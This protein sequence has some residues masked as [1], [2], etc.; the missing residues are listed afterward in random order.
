MRPF[1]RS[2]P[3]IK[4][5]TEESDASAQDIAENGTITFIDLDDVASIALSTASVTLSSGVTLPDG[6]QNTLTNGFSVTNNND[7]TASWSISLSDLD[8][9]FLDAD[10]TITVNFVV[11]ATDDQSAT[12]SDT[13]SLV[14]TGSN[15]TPTITS[16][17]SRNLI[18]VGDNVAGVST[19]TAT[20]TIGDLDQGDTAA[21]D[22][23]YLENNGWVPLQGDSYYEK[24]LSHGSVRIY[25]GSTLITYTL[26]SE[27]NAVDELQSGQTLTETVSVAVISNGETVY[28]DV[29]F[30]INGTNDTPVTTLS[31]YPPLRLALIMKVRQL[32]P[33][34]R[35][36]RLMPCLSRFRT[37]MTTAL[38]L[39]RLNYMA[40]VM[41]WFRLV[42]HQILMAS[43]LLV[44]TAR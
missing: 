13:V 6:M 4:S 2:L 29:T 28:H 26:D 17:V 16:N 7:N 25:A 34:I 18:E 42:P 19:A 32:R 37:L 39:R 3:L 24:T 8:L 21:I 14:I 41:L 31:I 38:L 43:L 27:D 12:A 5:V 1:C 35:Q 10:E 15:D 23:E 11:T 9:D 36:G 33:L 44:Y 30:T 20:L 40:A 22:F